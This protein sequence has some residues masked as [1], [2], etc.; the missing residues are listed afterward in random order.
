[1]K[2]SDTEQRLIMYAIDSLFAIGA[3]GRAKLHPDAERGLG[4]LRQRAC[5]YR[6]KRIE[7][8]QDALAV[9]TAPLP[10]PAAANDNER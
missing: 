3:A 2:L 9:L 8:Q 4:T 10:P 1:M 7:Q 5:A 6:D